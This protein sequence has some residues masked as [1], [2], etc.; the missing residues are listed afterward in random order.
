MLK[1]KKELVVQRLLHVLQTALNKW[2]II[3]NVVIYNFKPNLFDNKERK[4]QLSIWRR[5]A[6]SSNN[7]CD[8]SDFLIYITE[9]CFN[10]VPKY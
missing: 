7:F 9:W 2:L 5:N 8:E 3:W 10:I 4:Q 6:E 1:L